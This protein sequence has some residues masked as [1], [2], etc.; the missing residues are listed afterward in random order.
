MSRFLPAQSRFPALLRGLILLAL[1]AAVAL[2]PDDEPA[3]RPIHLPGTG[4]DGLAEAVL[5]PGSAP[6]F[7]A[8][9]SP[10]GT[11]ELDALGAVAGRALYAELPRDAAPLTAVPPFAPMAGRSAAV[12]VRVPAVDTARV[13]RLL[14]P[15]DAVLDSTR[16]AP[17]A[18]AAGFRVRPSRAGWAEWRVTLGS[19]MDTA[20]AWVAPGRP[21]RVLVA[22]GPP[23]WESRY[24]VRALEA[25]GAEVS[26]V[27]DLGRGNII[28]AGAPETWWTDDSLADHDVVVLLPG[29]NLQATEALATF[30]RLGGG[31]A[32]AGAWTVG[33]AEDGGDTG[34]QADPAP[35]LATLGLARAVRSA[36]TAADSVRW[37]TP[38]AVAPLP[39]RDGEHAVAAFSAPGPAA[40]VA[41]RVGG[42]PAMLLAPY[43]RGRAAAVGLTETWRW[44]LAGEDA[45]HRAFWR[46]LVDWLTASPPV[47]A[48]EAVGASGVVGTTVRFRDRRPAD[49][50][51]SP[52]SPTLSLV[53]PGSDSEEPLPM[54]GG[55]GRFVAVDTGVHAI[56]L[57]GRPVAAFRAVGADV[58]GA[59]SDPGSRA[60]L[61]LLASASRGGA[62]EPDAFDALVREHGAGPGLEIPWAA[63]LFAV[64]VTLC[65]AE[66]AL[67]RV[68]GLP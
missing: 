41:A 67:R 23:D 64:L 12:E 30:V 39:P 34:G 62:L 58:A 28:S 29:A 51:S 22:T 38:P 10:P 66:W 57:E 59:A 65:T 56:R 45:G 16:V 33:E 35:L 49:R 14:G 15:G 52:S 63:L 37:S 46:T 26:L 25:S 27:Q 68:R 31:L 18:T 19:A 3:A 42:A 20:Q 61:T 21:P 11:L 36:G 48:M 53:R 4:P 9:G 2:W 32:L 7:R 8:A 40:T 54:V 17:G 5:R 1:A 43:G 6:V 60:R 13:A 55:K 44:V 50:A 24:L 47:F